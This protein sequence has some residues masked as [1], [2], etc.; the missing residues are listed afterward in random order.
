MNIHTHMHAYTAC[1]T[2]AWP[3]RK[4]TYT[5]IHTHTYSLLYFSMAAP[6]QITATT[7]SHGALAAPTLVLMY[8]GFLVAAL[9]DIQKSL[10]KLGETDKVCVC[11]Y[12]CTCLCV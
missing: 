10:V 6:M 3:H 4:Y 9:G 1:S 5:H 12:I 11:V 8:A 2:S 7:T